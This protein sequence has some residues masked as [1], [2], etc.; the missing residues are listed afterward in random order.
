MRVK[1]WEVVRL[2]MRPTIARS[3]QH[4]PFFTSLI[5]LVV[6]VVV[7]PLH[8]GGEGV[9][10]SSLACRR[11]PT[12]V[13]EQFLIRQTRPGNS[14]RWNTY[15]QACVPNRPPNEGVLGPTFPFKQAKPTRGLEPRTPSLRVSTEEGTQSAS[16]PSGPVRKPKPRPPEDCEEP[17]TT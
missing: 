10:G 7:R 14:D 13:P 9:S 12:L 3:G 17:G 4:Q 5:T 15:L 6:K 2:E 11:A 1:P 8:F 16:V